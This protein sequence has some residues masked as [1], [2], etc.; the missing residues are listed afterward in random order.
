MRRYISFVASLFGLALLIS[1]IA[2]GLFAKRFAQE[3]G[4]LGTARETKS[5]PSI[6]WEQLLSQIGELRLSGDKI[7]GVEASTGRKFE[8][9]FEELL[10]RDGIIMLIEPK[11]SVLGK[12][13]VDATIE[14]GQALLF[15]QQR[16]L[17]FVGDV[18]LKSL[19]HAVTLKS[20]KV[21]WWWEKGKV[22]ATGNVFVS[23]SEGL[24]GGGGMATADIA[25]G[26]IELANKPYLQL[27]TRRLITR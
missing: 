3:E 27:S 25:L 1:V 18:T 7:T 26:E 6:S 17:E 4:E 22:I 11:C 10:H 23:A 13:G 16:V 19:A 12:C 9:G 2:V 20:G 24:S 15:P 5:M 8:I 14:S 21:K